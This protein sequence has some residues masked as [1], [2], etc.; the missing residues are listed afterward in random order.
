MPKA[1]PKP[2]TTAPN[3]AP[4]FGP[5]AL[6]YLETCLEFLEDDIVSVAFVAKKA[7]AEVDNYTVE[8]SLLSA[9]RALTRRFEDLME[10]FKEMKATAPWN[11]NIKVPAPEGGA[12]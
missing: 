7:A 6:A 1:D 3:A 5:A 12:Q 8:R 9:T 11:P 2:T 4:A 10:S